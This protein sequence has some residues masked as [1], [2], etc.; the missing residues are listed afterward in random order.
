M[1]FFPAQE[2]AGAQIKLAVG[3]L[4]VERMA[5]FEY[6]GGIEKEWVIFF[7]IM[8]VQEVWR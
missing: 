2:A 5:I 8:G 3:N 4:A 1:S 7:Y 6:N